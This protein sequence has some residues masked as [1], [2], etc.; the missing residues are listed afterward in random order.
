MSRRLSTW[1]T[2]RRV[3]YHLKIPSFLEIP[4][5]VSSQSSGHIPLTS[6]LSPPMAKFPWMAPP[7]P[8]SLCTLVSLVLLEWICFLSPPLYFLPSFLILTHWSLWESSVQQYTPRQ[9]WWPCISSQVVASFIAGL[10]RDRFSPYPGGFF[11][12]MASP[13]V[14]VGVS[15]FVFLSINWCVIYIFFHG[16]PECWLFV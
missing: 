2:R 12:C 1:L 7:S 13:L 6:W 8:F 14:S 9:F 15:F 3:L 4:G 16:L 10:T 11:P 5:V